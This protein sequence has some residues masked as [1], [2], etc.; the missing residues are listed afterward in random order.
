MATYQI[1]SQTTVPQLKDSVVPYTL[2]YTGFN[3][4]IPQK[5]DLKYGANNNDGL[6]KFDN[7][8]YYELLDNSPLTYTTQQV[9]H[10]AKTITITNTTSLMRDGSYNPLTNTFDPVPTSSSYSVSQQDTRVTYAPNF[11]IIIYY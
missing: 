4:N 11:P 3:T 10:L 1:S 9:N 2:F 7:T 8:I 5:T 6:Y